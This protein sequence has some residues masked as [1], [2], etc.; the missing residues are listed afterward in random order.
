MV[1]ML[2]FGAGV[3]VVLLAVW[4]FTDSDDGGEA[5]PSEYYWSREDMRDL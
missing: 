1:E 4:L 2:L 3:I 5:P